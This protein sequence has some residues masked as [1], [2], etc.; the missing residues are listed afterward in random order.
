[1]THSINTQEAIEAWKHAH[2]FV[3]DVYKLTNTWPREEHYGLIPKVRNS[4]V[5]IASNVV[6]GYARQA[7]E[8]YLAH[9]TDSQVALEE[10]KYSLLVARDLGYLS[11]HHYDQVM[12]N[13]EALSE[14]LAS[15]H[16]E[17]AGQPKVLPSQ[18]ATGPFSV[19]KGVREALAD[20][21]TWLKGGSKNARGKRQRHE[22]EN[23]VWTEESGR[24]GYLEEANDE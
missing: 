20:A 16:T 12:N 24:S 13:A 5:K 14:Q 22:S 1:M 2:R 15:L 11:E 3:L 9:L 10:T 7:P 21:F 23:P 8:Q 17:L 4:S 18:G 19:T 6:E